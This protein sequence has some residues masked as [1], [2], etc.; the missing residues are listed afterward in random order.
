MMI[1]D[2]TM[3][4]SFVKMLVLAS[5]LF[6][7][8]ATPG[9]SCGYLF[10]KPIGDGT[11][12]RTNSICWDGARFVAV[13]ASGT[14]LTSSDGLSWTPQAPGVN[15]DFAHVTGGNGQSLAAGFKGFLTS[16]DGEHWAGTTA[17]MFNLRGLDYQ[18][19]FFFALRSTGV[20]S[21]QDGFHWSMLPLGLPYDPV[22]GIAY[23]NGLYV[24]A[25]QS[26]VL[27]TSSDA[28]HW[29]QGYLPVTTGSYVE[30]VAFENGV[31]V[32]SEGDV[33]LWS[34]DG[35]VWSKASSVPAGTCFAHG[36]GRFMIVS[37]GWNATYTSTDGD[38]W[39][40][41]P[42]TGV[43]SGTFFWQIAYGSGVYAAATNIGIGVS[44]DGAAW[45]FPSGGR[46]LPGT[47]LKYYE[48]IGLFAG[49]NF[50]LTGQNRALVTSPDGDHWS[51]YPI[52]APSW[53]L[54]GAF[55]NFTHGGGRWVGVG[56]NGLWASSADGINWTTDKFPGGYWLN[57]VAYGAGT[58]VIVGR[59]GIVITSP[60]ATH[61]T[62]KQPQ[63]S[64]SLEGI[65]FY[66]GL[67]VAVG[68]NGTLVTSPNGETWTH[69]PMGVHDLRYVYAL[70]TGLVVSGDFYC[71]L[72]QDGLS[73]TTVGNGWI[74]TPM[75][76]WQGHYMAGG[77][78]DDWAFYGTSDD[79]LNWTPVQSNMTNPYPMV[80][81]GQVL[82]SDAGTIVDHCYPVMSSISPLT[83]PEAGETSLRITGHQLEGIQSVTLGGIPA[84]NLTIGSDTE[85]TVEA[86][87]CTVMDVL[88]SAESPEGP[89]F[90]D[91]VTLLP[92]SYSLAL[93]AS[94]VTPSVLS[95]RGNKIFCALGS[96]LSPNCSLSLSD[97]S[98]LGSEG[99]TSFG[100]IGYASDHAPGTFDLTVT[101]D[102]GAT[103]IIPQ[104]VTFVDTADP[105]DVVLL[106]GPTRL[107]VYANVFGA[108]FT[109]G[110]VIQ[111][112]GL[113]LTTS[114]KSATKLIGK[115]PNF[116]TTL[117]KGLT[118]KI[119]VISA[120]GI[121][122][123]P[124]VL[125]R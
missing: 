75:V 53:W 96:G 101:R 90:A 15:W 5:A 91:A 103:A 106:S 16:R 71:A 69:Q 31:F 81:D 29:A 6:L 76:Y 117:S 37:P 9:Q 43:P 85:F 80:T 21:S 100:V 54:N 122:S 115:V 22:M 27:Y 104:A 55:L 2:R 120:E 4:A 19:G 63:S 94:G 56:M 47:P 20:L 119:S 41:T 33:I 32:V 58:Y 60:D 93:T 24:A 111:V 118:H 42:L 86:P 52:P 46:A 45:H 61:W 65:A 18:G 12:T 84:P 10:F 36:G 14:I 109:R 105:A 44:S 59:D 23:G 79:L 1:G 8:V 74:S 72:S 95:T 34:R 102:D 28:V 108:P 11:Q 49:P 48:D 64:F 97:G 13:G 99:G 89:A 50:D 62:V 30:S 78:F 38:H 124:F 3:L 116:S 17:G 70:P 87:S 51:A 125:R 110:C 68:N 35:K 67:F 123:A 112:D 92:F 26:E 113:P 98:Y 77:V 7:G 114:F 88:V 82:L 39:T 73:W 83:R 107:R 121:V 66:R 40:S 57:D 25:T